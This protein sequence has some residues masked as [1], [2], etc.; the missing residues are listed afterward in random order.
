[1]ILTVTAD[2]QPVS[3]IPSVTE[4]ELTNTA[5]DAPSPPQTTA[6][7][8]QPC[9]ANTSLLPRELQESSDDTRSVC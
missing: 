6:S 7:S 5:R 3:S 9:A 4:G 2:N 1:M 8:A